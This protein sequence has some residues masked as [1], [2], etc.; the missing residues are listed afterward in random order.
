[1]PFD[2]E[3]AFGAE[4]KKKTVSILLM[5]YI[6]MYEFITMYAYVHVYL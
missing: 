4:I 3:I 6:E 2:L 5:L 1:M